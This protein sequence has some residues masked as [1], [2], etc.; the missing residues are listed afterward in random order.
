[1]TKIKKLKRSKTYKY[2]VNRKRLKKKLQKTPTVPCPQIKAAWNKKETLTKN[3]EN[4]GL[5]YDSNV[6]V[7][8]PSSNFKSKLRHS[9]SEKSDKPKPTKT[10][11]V[12]EL[13]EDAH[14]PRER[15]FKLPTGRVRW[16][17][18]LMDKYGEDY[19]AMAKDKKNHYQDTWKQLRAQIKQ[20]KGIPEQ[21][22][23]YL[24]SKEIQT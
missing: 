3:L 24:A 16:L 18:Y 22:N 11:V 13:E 5:A 12:M 7:A 17:T 8:I 2:N 21:Y 9:L 10:H 6:S 15:S 1:M 20:F 4:M 14:A 23:E 19:K